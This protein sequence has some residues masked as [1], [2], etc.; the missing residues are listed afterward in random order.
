MFSFS[1]DSKESSPCNSKIT[2]PPQSM[3]DHEEEEEE[4]SNKIT[5]IQVCLPHVQFKL[6][7]WQFWQIGV[8]VDEIWV[9]IGMQT[10]II[11][12]VAI[13]WPNF[14]HAIIGSFFKYLS[15]FLITFFS[16]LCF[17]LSLSLKPS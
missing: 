16:H 13:C 5:V 17:S 11:I 4:E 14:K 8:R 9:Y 2:S 6:V 7:F 15:L 12:F 1:Q 3:N 10:C